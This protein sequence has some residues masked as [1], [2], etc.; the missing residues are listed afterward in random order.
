MWRLISVEMA[1]INQ[2]LQEK[3]QQIMVLEGERV[4]L[5]NGRKRAEDK[6]DQLESQMSELKREKLILE[7]KGGWELS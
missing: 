5:E 1:K 2:D 6:V 7:A 4:I 3:K